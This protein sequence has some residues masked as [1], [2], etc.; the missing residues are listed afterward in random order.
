MTYI[1]GDVHGKYECLKELMEK[2]PLNSRV[3]FVGD[4]I[5][6]G[7]NSKKVVEF[8]RK[9]EYECV[10]GNHEDLMIKYGKDFVN[11]YPKR[12]SEYCKNWI[13]NGGDV[14]IKSY[15][16]MDKTDSDKLLIN[17]KMLELFTDDIEWMESLPLYLELDLK[18]NNKPI[19]VSHS[20]IADKWDTINK[21]SDSFRKYALWNR[22]TPSK[23]NNIFNIF[24]HTP[25]KRANIARHYINIDT[26][27][28]KER[29]GFGKLSAYCVEKHEV[30]SVSQKIK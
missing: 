26:G 21:K 30:L 9:N 8:V 6:R 28:Y 4:L 24:G 5:D 10:L 7:E 19:V 14:T 16:L 25:Q 22:T 3:I 11:N 12:I 13:Y 1:V 23:Y 15:A 27:C 20:S 29:V 2:I 18:K 17:P